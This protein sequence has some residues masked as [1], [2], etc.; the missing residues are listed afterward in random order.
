VIRMLFQVLL[1]FMALLSV[2][3]QEP[4]ADRAAWEARVGAAEKDNPAYAFVKDD[5]ALPRVLIIG[6]SISIGYT[7]SVRALLQ[8]NANVHRIPANGGDTKKGLANIETW[9]GEGRWDVIHFNWGLHDIKRLRD[10]KPDITADRANSPEVYAENL[11]ALAERLKKTRAKLI[12]AATTPVPEGADMRLPGD[13]IEYN[14]IAADIM[15]ELKIPTNDLHSYVRPQLGMYQRPAN[16]HYLPEGY[17][18]LAV[19]VAD[20]IKTA[21]GSSE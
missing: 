19:R 17:E 11:R 9:L 7:P 20:Q 4:A 2:R 21:L 6:D 18:F 8:G 13:E 10:N 5:P 12:W 3:A 16:V 1:I 14:K 15:A